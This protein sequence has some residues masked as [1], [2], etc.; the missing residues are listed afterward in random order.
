MFR[1]CLVPIQQAGINTEPAISSAGAISAAGAFK[2]DDLFFR[3]M[4]SDVVGRRKASIPSPN[5]DHIN[6][7]AAS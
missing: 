2:E 5:N 3:N 6:V 4:F 7:V 1:I